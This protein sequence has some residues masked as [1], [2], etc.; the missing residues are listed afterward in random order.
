MQKLEYIRILN[1]VNLPL[2][3]SEERDYLISIARI[4]GYL[5][6]I[7]LDFCN[8][9]YYKVNYKLFEC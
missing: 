6:R 8:T 2:K 9:F 7:N 5:G 4:T 3:I 1:I